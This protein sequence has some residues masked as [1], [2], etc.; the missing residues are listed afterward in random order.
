MKQ[1][2]IVNDVPREVLGKWLRLNPA[3]DHPVYRIGP[4]DGR[5]VAVGPWTRTILDEP[6]RWDMTIVTVVDQS[7]G[8]KYV[9]PSHSPT[10]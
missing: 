2:V 7:A 10:A 9:R 3:P 8:L 5:Y 1:A 6:G 4:R